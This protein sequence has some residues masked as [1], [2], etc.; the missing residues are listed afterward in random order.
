VEEITLQARTGRTN[1]SS[2]SRRLRADGSVPAVVYGHGISPVALD[3]DAR[4]LWGA[5][6]TPAGA[7]ALITL[8]VDGDSHLTMAG[9]LQR[10]PVRST[11]RHVDFVV[12]RRDEV[13][14]AE[15][16]VSLVGE[17]EALHRTDGIVGQMTFTLD[18][19]A[20]PADIPPTI[21]VD[22]SALEIGDTIRV[23]DLRLGS[24]VEVEADPDQAVV[25]GQPPTAIEEEEEE[26]EEEAAAM[27]EGEEAAPAEEAGGEAAV[28]GSAAHGRRL[29]ETP[30]SAAPAEG[31][32]RAA[33]G[34]G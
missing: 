29:A 1:G 27:A 15:V 6:T 4:Q 20:L 34:A 3:V 12:V 2:A 23:A 7:N 5:L 11:I 24:G 30:G 26:E 9:E 21:E 19:R 10:H 14:E 28:P 33:G 8:E 18:I 25:I 16:S 17:P 22:I 32:G 31:A 13:V